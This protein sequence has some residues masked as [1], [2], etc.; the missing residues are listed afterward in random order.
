[1]RYAIQ[2]NVLHTASHH[3]NGV[4]IGFT[5]IAEVPGVSEA[6]INEATLENI[7]LAIKRLP[8]K[9]KP[10]TAV[11][12]AFKAYQGANWPNVG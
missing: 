5:P 3:L 1:M 4:V 6:Q 12:T 2:L 8:H 7:E 11:P 9:I 10:M